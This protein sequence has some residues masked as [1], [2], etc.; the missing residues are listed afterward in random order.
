M[1]ELL[2]DDDRRG[3]AHHEPVA[4][5]IEGS[6]APFWIVISPRQGAHRA[7]ARDP[8]LVDRRLGSPAEHH[9]RAAEPD[10]VGSVADRHVRR[11][12]GRALG[13]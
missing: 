4:L 2:Q 6:A 9:V 7:E 3:F 10:L 13:R 1:L 8:D 11:G 5:G 12:A